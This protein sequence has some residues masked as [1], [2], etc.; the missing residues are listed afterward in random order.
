MSA[1]SCVQNTSELEPIFALFA[2]AVVKVDI[3]FADVGFRIRAGATRGGTSTLWSNER[4]I[5]KGT[6]DPG[7]DCFDQ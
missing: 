1:S 7:V 3:L 5:A 2:A 4:N 6:T